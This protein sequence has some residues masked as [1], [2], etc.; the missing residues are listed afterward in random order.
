M[1]EGNTEIA[2]ILTESRRQGFS[3][4]FVIVSSNAQHRQAAQSFQKGA[5]AIVL[6]ADPPDTLTEAINTLRVSDVWLPDSYMREAVRWI[7]QPLSEREKA[8]LIA[9]LKGSTTKEIATQLRITDGAV[10]HSIQV[11][12]RKTGSHNRAQLISMCLERYAHLL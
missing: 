12:F 2:H 10:K 11:L 9:L 3:G 4:R 5:G 7:Q 6:T 8:I 1:Q